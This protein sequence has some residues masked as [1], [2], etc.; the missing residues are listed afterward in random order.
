[1]VVDKRETVGTITY[2]MLL[3]TGWS[4]LLH[5]PAIPTGRYSFLPHLTQVLVSTEASIC[6]QTR[7]GPG[8]RLAQA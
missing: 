4:P 3:A 7:M 8:S 1:V 5:L 6:N 2:A